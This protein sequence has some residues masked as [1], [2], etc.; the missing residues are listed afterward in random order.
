MRDEQSRFPHRPGWQWTWEHTSRSRAQLC[1]I[2]VNLKWVRS[3]TNCRAY[4]NP[5]LGSD[6]RILTVPFLI[7]FRSSRGTKCKC[8]RI[9]CEKLSQTLGLQANF[10]LAVSNRFDALSLPDDDVQVLYFDIVSTIQTAA[11][12]VAV[13]PPKRSTHRW[14]SARTVDLVRQRHAAMR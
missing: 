10:A 5:E 8:F 9:D 4:N 2:L 3:V 6:H 7:R 14:V 1:H 12:E 11:E 13:K